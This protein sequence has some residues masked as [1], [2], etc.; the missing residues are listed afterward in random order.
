MDT[1]A[2]SYFGHA[3]QFA[4]ILQANV[5]A[6][7]DRL[8]AS[9][10]PPY[11]AWLVVALVVLSLDAVR[12]AWPE[13]N[14]FQESFETTA[15]TPVIA[16][17]DSSPSVI[18]K[19][20]VSQVAASQDHFPPRSILWAVTHAVRSGTLQT[21]TANWMPRLHSVV[22]SNRSFSTFTQ[23]LDIALS[24]P[25]SDKTQNSQHSE[26]ATNSTGNSLVSL[27][28]PK[29]PARFSPSLCEC[30]FEY[31]PLCSA[32]TFTQPHRMAL[33]AVASMSKDFK[34]PKNH[35]SKLLRHSLVSLINRT[36]VCD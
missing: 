24:S 1:R 11:V 23:A 10:R 6:L 3:K 28:Q 7:I 19:A 14:V 36:G 17:S 33:A 4:F 30:G 22:V 26:L 25:S 8:L 13:P 20:L 12:I 9:C 27:L 35:S 34:F 5:V 32:D 18:L 21:A 16:D 29:A 15:S 31:D 2:A